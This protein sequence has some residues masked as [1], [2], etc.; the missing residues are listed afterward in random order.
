MLQLKIPLGPELWDEENEVFVTPEYVT[1]ELEHSLASL[2]E[3]ESKWCK[4]FL[5][6]KNLTPDEILD[7]IKCM[8]ITPNVDPI[9]FEFL[10]ESHIDQIRDYI[11]A[12]MTATTFSKDK[13]GKPNREIITAEI[14]YHWIIAY[15]IPFEYRHYH[16]NQL[17]TLIRVCSIKNGPTKKRNKRDTAAHYK[18]LNEARKRKHNTTG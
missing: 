3:W 5:H 8:T 7:Y 4:P 2:Q 13:D 6:T 16:I 14:I 1:L 12:P 18:A 17:L 10:N 15:Q 9:I 11:K